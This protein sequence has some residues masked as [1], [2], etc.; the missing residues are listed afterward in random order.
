MDKVQHRACL[1]I[2]GEIQGTSTEHLYEE[3]GLHS[4]VKRRLAQQ[5]SPFYK[6]VNCLLSDN[7]YYLDF[8]L[9][10]IIN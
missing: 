2:T 10:K 7:L 5:I 3:L 8:F 9:K 6:I 4:L 1:S